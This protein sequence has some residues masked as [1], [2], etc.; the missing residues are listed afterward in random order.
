MASST[1]S[2]P[3]PLANGGVP[4]P[5]TPAAAAKPDGLIL[6]PP[7]IRTIVD[8]TA[9]FVAKSP[10]PELFEDKI[11]AREKSDSRFAFLNKEDAYHAYYLHRLEAF[12][13]GEVAEVKADASKAAAAEGGEDADDNDGRPPEPPALEYLVEQPPAMNAVDLCVLQPLTLP[14]ALKLTEPEHC[15]GISYA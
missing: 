5:A 3:P 12:R 14:L 6:P 2:L 10:K 11:R 7:E 13:G 1:L 4:A 9:S 8:K 15:P